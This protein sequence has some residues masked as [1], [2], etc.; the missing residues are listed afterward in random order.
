M[1]SISSKA[2]LEKTKSKDMQIRRQGE[3]QHL[4]LLSRARDFYQSF[5]TKIEDA[6]AILI[7]NPF[8]TATSNTSLLF[9]RHVMKNK[10]EESYFMALQNIEDK[11]RSRSQITQA[12]L[13]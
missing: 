10:R 4:Q 5:T 6:R 3:G 9:R 7:S 1:S 13:F 12:A 11:S 8:A 2:N